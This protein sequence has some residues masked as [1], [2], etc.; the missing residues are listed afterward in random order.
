MDFVTEKN[1]T[2]F[3]FHEELYVR[4]ENL[5]IKI[6]YLPYFFFLDLKKKGYDSDIIGRNCPTYNVLIL[7]KIHHLDIRGKC[8]NFI[9]YLYLSI[10]KGV[11]VKVVLSHQFCLIYSLMIFFNNYDKYGISIGNK[12][13]CGGLF[14]R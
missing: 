6:K 13:C 3:T 5:K 2:V 7:M 11:F 10:K 1:V 12:R 9:E 8:Y 4:D 14:C